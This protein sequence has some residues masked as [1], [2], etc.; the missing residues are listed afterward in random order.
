MAY[1]DTDFMRAVVQSG[2]IS[3]APYECL[4]ETPGEKSSSHPHIFSG[5]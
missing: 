3:G 1:I 4:V 5:P 2:K